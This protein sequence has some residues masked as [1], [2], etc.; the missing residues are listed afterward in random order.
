MG[1]VS[2]LKFLE[3]CLSI[4]IY[5]KNSR[6]VLVFGVPIFDPAWRLY[7]CSIVFRVLVQHLINACREVQYLIVL[8][9]RLVSHATHSL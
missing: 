6:L 3:R 8:I 2:R 7:L 4:K 1:V 9:E 5:T